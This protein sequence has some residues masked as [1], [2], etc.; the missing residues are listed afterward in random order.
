MVGVVVSNS[1]IRAGAAMATTTL[2]TL[3]GAAAEHVPDLR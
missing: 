1:D 2:G 3:G